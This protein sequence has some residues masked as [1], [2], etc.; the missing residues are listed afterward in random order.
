M[1]PG[2]LRAVVTKN[3]DWGGWGA[4]D[5]LKGGRHLHAA[6]LSLAALLCGGGCDGDIKRLWNDMGWCLHSP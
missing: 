5:G 3:A 1:K 2:P 6:H 4:K